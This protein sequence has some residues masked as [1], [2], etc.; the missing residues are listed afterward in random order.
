MH[1]GMFLKANMFKLACR[2]KQFL[3]VFWGGMF[4]GIPVSVNL[5]TQAVFEY[6]TV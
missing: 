2:K 5:K 3:D 1:T 6:M 4:N